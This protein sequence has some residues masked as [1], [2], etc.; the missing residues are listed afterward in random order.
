[1]IQDRK[2]RP[3]A[4]S[5]TVANTPEEFAKFVRTDIARWAK[6]IRDAHVKVD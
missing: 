1:M 6:V 3:K 5:E 2:L 4:A